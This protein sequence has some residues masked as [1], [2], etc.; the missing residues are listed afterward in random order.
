M[1]E[2][3]NGPLPRDPIERVLEEARRLANDEHADSAK[4]SRRWRDTCCHLELIWSCNVRS[5][6][7]TDLLNHCAWR[8]NRVTQESQV[9]VGTDSELESY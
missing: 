8:S 5:A 7:H 6:P 1:D 3:V 4:V 9:R 2:I